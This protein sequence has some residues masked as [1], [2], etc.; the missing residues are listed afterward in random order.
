M[1]FWSYK[2]LLCALC[3]LFP[4]VNHAE[5][6]TDLPGIDA[7]A[8][9]QYRGKVVLVDFWASWCGPCARSFPWM[10]KMQDKYRKNGFV[11]LAVNLDSER[12]LAD[13]FVAQYQPNFDVIYDP[14]GRSAEKFTVPAMPTSVIFGRDGNVM[15]RHHGFLEKDLAEYEKN[16]QQALAAG[17]K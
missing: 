1:K 8:A 16:I 4:L 3:F 14:Q 13:Q 6:L 15:K 12:Q 9:A 2:H 10:K 17:T 5:R 11:I 7:S